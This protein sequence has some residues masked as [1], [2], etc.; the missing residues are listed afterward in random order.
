MDSPLSSTVSLQFPVELVE[1]IA[2]QVSGRLV[3]ALGSTAEPW[4]LLSVDEVCVM[5]GRS[6]R[7]LFD[8]IKTKE[9]PHV[10]MGDRGSLRFDLDSI[11]RWA[12][13]RQIPPQPPAPRLN[14]RKTIGLPGA[15]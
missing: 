10:V 9:L 14:D 12:L 1:A 6:R 5:L 4:R 3:E 13:E 11:R 8:A 15:L 7:W 2:E